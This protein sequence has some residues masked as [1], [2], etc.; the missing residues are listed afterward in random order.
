MKRSIEDIIN[1]I[2]IEQIDLV[3]SI[4]FLG[5]KRGNKRNTFIGVRKKESFV[6][7]THIERAASFAE[8]RGKI[9]RACVEF[10]DLLHSDASCLSRQIYYDHSKFFPRLFRRTQF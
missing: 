10:S 6:V 8:K 1:F 3:G 9:V 7:D 5:H 4:S 2:D